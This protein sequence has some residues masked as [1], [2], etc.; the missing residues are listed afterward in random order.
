M[1]SE[2]DK[3]IIAADKTNAYPLPNNGWMK[4][5]TNKV[6]ISNWHPR[7]ILYIHFFLWIP[8]P[9]NQNRIFIH[10]KKE[11]NINLFDSHISRRV[12][13]AIQNTALFFNDNNRIVVRAVLEICSIYDKMS[14]R[15]RH[16]KK[17]SFENRNHNWSVKCLKMPLRALVRDIAKLDARLFVL[18]QF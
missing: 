5:P 18:I 12:G 16:K 8:L 15:N 11:K 1:Y 6:H 2:S 4:W 9:Y 3:I 13:D 14:K 17:I 10:L 7:I